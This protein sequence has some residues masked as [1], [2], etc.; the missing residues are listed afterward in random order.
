MSTSSRTDRGTAAHAGDGRRGGRG[1]PAD[2]LQ[3]AEQPRA[4]AP[5]HPGPG[6]AGHRAAR[7][8]AQ[9]GRPQPAH[10]LL[11][12]GRP[13][14]RPGRRGQRQRADGPVRALPG[15]E[16]RGGRLPR[17][18]VHRRRRRR[19]HRRRTTSCCAPPPSTRS[20]SPTPTAATR[21]PPGWPSSGVP[22]VAFGRPWEEPAARHPWVDV[23]GRAGVELAVDHLVERGHR[24]IAWVG[25]QKGSF[26]GEDR[27]SRLGRPDA[28]AR[29]VH[30]PA[31]S[32]RGD[33]TLEFGDAGRAR[34]ARR[35]G[36]PADRVRLRQRHRGD[37][38]AAGPRRRGA[39]G[40]AGD[41][42]VV[43]FD[44]SIA[45]QVTPRR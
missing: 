35:R 37:G 5:R 7:L 29:P 44:D 38:R 6:A 13:P 24:R 39:C 15:G 45:A 9:P 23:D 22:F 21:R 14:R 34:A 17:A 2:R 42:A 3:R 26:I 36:G 43:G 10:P 19:G 33:D 18:A 1:L 8:R 4:A 20:S 11:A 12:P 31:V 32:A 27:R 41:V 30:Q 25:W 40:P 28:R 16:H